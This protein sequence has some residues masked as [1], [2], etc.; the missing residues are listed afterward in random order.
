LY[1]L[2]EQSLSDRFVI[3]ILFLGVIV[4]CDVVVQVSYRAF[5][6]HDMDKY[7]DLLE[8]GKLDD[9]KKMEIKYRGLKKFLF[10]LHR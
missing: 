9:C 5:A 2:T 3:F 6:K 4:V 7:N 8:Q 1:G 10:R